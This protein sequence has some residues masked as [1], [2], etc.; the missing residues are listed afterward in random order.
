MR[1]SVRRLAAAAALLVI[2]GTA[3]AQAQD[4]EWLARDVEW[5]VAVERGDAVTIRN[6]N[7]TITAR[8]TNASQV[9]VR[10]RKEADDDDPDAV[11]IEVVEDA[12]GVLICAVYPSRRGRD[13]N[14]CGRGDDYRMSVRN[15]DVKVHFTIEVPAGVGL[16]ARTI[17]GDIEAAG[18]SA[19]VEARTVNGDIAVDGSGAVSTETVNGDI[20][21][22]ADQWTHRGPPLQDYER[23]HS[24]R[25][26][27]RD[28]C[29]CRHLD[30]QRRHRYGVPAHDPRSLGTEIGLRRDRRRRPRHRTPHRQRQHRPRPRRLT[31]GP[32]SP[33]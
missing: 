18:M 15:N 5:Q 19:G 31:P 22:A 12:R 29:G 6:V 25:P 28:R 30:G 23:R 8:A 4:L 20:A 33:A 13:P 27:G 3:A 10:V 14:R 9:R 26:A 24:A 21:G 1:N 16:E 17:N 2:S 11:R 7:G 32:F